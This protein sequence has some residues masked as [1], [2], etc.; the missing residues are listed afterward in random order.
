MLF[1]LE[2][3]RTS[4][5]VSGHCPFWKFPRAS[6]RTNRS[7]I[8]ST[9]DTYKI[10][11]KKKNTEKRHVSFWRKKEISCKYFYRNIYQ[12]VV[13]RRNQFPKSQVNSCIRSIRNDN[14]HEIPMPNNT[15]WNSS[16]TSFRLV[17]RVA[18]FLYPILGNISTANARRTLYTGHRLSINNV[19]ISNY[20]ILVSINST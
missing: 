9:T 14:K 18:L 17:T 7:K 19:F 4:E 20:G 3:V 11:K 15:Q 2:I 12:K 10:K 16:L 6:W 5:H 13:R 8:V 1:P